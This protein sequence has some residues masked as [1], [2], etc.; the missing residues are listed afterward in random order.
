MLL[1]LCRIFLLSRIPVTSDSHC[2]SAFANPVMPSTASNHTTKSRIKESGSRRYP[3]MLNSCLDSE[4]FGHKYRAN[5]ENATWWTSGGLVHRFGRF[6]SAGEFNVERAF[7][8]VLPHKSNREKA[9]EAGRHGAWDEAIVVHRGQV[10]P[11]SEGHSKGVCAHPRYDGKLLHVFWAIITLS[12]GRWTARQRG[13]GYCNDSATLDRACGTE[14]GHRY[15]L[16]L[17]HRNK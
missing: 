16:F 5:N 8:T 1:R 17:F 7:G 6:A 2:W 14:P 9:S 12:C 3:Q 13:G 10:M 11:N 4:L 15:L